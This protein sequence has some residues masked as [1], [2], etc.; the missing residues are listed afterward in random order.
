MSRIF[1]FILLISL[2]TGLSANALYPQESNTGD[3]DRLLNKLATTT[4]SIEV[5]DLCIEIYRFYKFNQLTDNP[6]EV[7]FLLRAL[8]IYEQAEDWD[9]AA[10]VYN[11]IAGMNYNRG[12]MGEAKRYWEKA[13]ELYQKSGNQARLGV[14]YNNIS[15]VYQD[16]TEIA[17]SLRKAYLEKA[18]G[19]YLPLGDSSHLSS[20]YLNLGSL[21][22][23]DDRFDSAQ[24]YYQKALSLARALDRKNTI[25]ATLLH[26]GIMRRA[27]DRLSEAIANV[28][29][30][31]AYNA[32]RDTDPNAMRAYQ[33]LAELYEVTGDYK[34]AHVNFKRFSQAQNDLFEI[35]KNRQLIELENRFNIEKKEREI[36]L[37]KERE[38]IQSQRIEAE[39]KVK[40]YLGILVMVTVIGLIATGVLYQKSRKRSAE[41]DRQKVELEKLNATKDRFFGIIAHDLRNPVISFQG[42]SRLIDSY[43]KK[44][45]TEKIGELSDKIQHSVNNLNQLLDNLLNWASSQ[46]STLPYQPEPL[47]VGQV[48][49]EAISLFSDTAHAKQIQISLNVEEGTLIYADRN[50]VST[51]FRNLVN[52]A[53]KFTPEGGRIEISAELDKDNV[54]I[55]TT[56]NGVGIEKSKISSLFQLSN[57]KSTQGTSGERGT[58]LGLVLCQEFAKANKGLIWVE[59]ELSK[60]TSFYV[61]MPLFNE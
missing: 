57:D 51:I 43:L 32:I 53:L 24:V 9:N 59:S 8:S 48:I 33:E 49:S 56:D 14:M 30:S 1:R 6:N 21:Y 35:T 20:A 60:G 50:G 25:Q 11:S 12:L 5:A 28:E 47:P 23:D 27:Q 52:N 19:I 31:I 22:R 58:G 55:V 45:K 2:A 7:T 46:T 41:I 18:V 61:R 13:I 17:R 54:K 26:I 36:A 38:A 37:L 16:S 29:A 40:N 42:I 4:D 44:G 15:L 10:Y 3:I 34:K 39:Q